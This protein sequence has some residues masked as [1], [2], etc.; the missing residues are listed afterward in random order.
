VPTRRRNPPT[1]RALRP[2]IPHTSP[3]PPLPQRPPRRQ[4]FQ[5]TFADLEA[6]LFSRDRGLF[7]AEAFTFGGFLWAAATVRSRA[8]APL[9][10]EAIALVPLADQVRLSPGPL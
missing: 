10:G 5:Q 7:P 4:F 3:Q 2:A 8:H 9:D 6:S 1:L